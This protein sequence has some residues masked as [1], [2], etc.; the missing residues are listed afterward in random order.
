MCVCVHV[1]VCLCACVCVQVY[2][3]LFTCQCA[4]LNMG[5]S[6]E[7]GFPAVATDVSGSCTSLLS[8]P[9]PARQSV[10]AYCMGKCVSVMCISGAK[11]VI[12]PLIQRLLRLQWQFFVL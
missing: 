9:F 10:P 11:F 6:R 3:C 7:L 5:G 8:A 1:H 12:S 4:C 2:M